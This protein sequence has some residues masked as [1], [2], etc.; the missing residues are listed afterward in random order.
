MRGSDE[1]SGSLFSYVD[2]E[3]RVRPDHPLRTIRE[4]VNAALGD[5]SK[6]FAG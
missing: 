6:A 2:L 3:A 1:R 4:I 5:L